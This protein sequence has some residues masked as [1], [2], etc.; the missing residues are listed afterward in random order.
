MSLQGPS[1]MPEDWLGGVRVQQ[2]PERKLTITVQNERRKVNLA[3][4]S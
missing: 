4:N 3:V 2:Q 1:A